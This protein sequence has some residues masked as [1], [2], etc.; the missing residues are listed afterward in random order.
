MHQP[1][2]QINRTTIDDILKR[3][4]A[5]GYE[6]LKDKNRLPDPEK[7]TRTFSPPHSNLKQ[8]AHKHFSLPELSGKIRNTLSKRKS[9]PLEVPMAQSLEAFKYGGP[10]SALKRS[11]LKNRHGPKE[12]QR[13]DV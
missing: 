4:A 12:S 8:V 13:T 3:W 7:C 5:E 9:H 10:E 11:G 6:G 2:M 1:Y